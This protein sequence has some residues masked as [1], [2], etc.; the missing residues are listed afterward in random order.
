VRPFSAIPDL[1][2][3]LRDAGVRVDIASSAKKD[4]LREYLD[5]ARIADLVD[6][7]TTSYLSRLPTSSRC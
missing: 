3:R 4:E 7:K 2:R 6:V 1:L 5:I